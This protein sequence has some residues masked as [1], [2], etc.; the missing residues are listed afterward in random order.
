MYFFHNSGLMLQCGSEILVKRF[1]D[2]NPKEETFEHFESFIKTTNDKN[3]KLLAQVTFEHCLGY[4]VLKAGIR[5]C[6]FTYFWVGKSML[7]NL[8]FA[9]QHPI[10]RKLNLYLDF[11]LAQMPLEMY[12]QYKSTIGLKI[13]GKGSSD[14][15]T[16][17]GFDFI[18]EWVNKDLK[19]H[20][21]WAPSH[22]AWLNACRS[23]NLT[24]DLLSSINQWLPISR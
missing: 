4:F 20:L 19:Q 6:N 11:D 18:V 8:F 22:K 13:E 5:Q 1:I 12:Q 16:C 17:E 2:S 23:F 21:S 7:K 24:K 15:T 3:V 14:K 10:Y 9:K